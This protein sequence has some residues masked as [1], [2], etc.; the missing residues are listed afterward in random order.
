MC[1]IAGILSFTG[2]PTA[3]PGVDIPRL[4]QIAGNI[5]E[6][7]FEACRTK[8]GFDAASYMGGENT[9][10][11]FFQ[12]VRRLKNTALFT[13]I[14]QT[15]AILAELTALARRLSVIIDSEAGHFSDQVGF[16]PS[17]SVDA[18]SGRIECLKDI[19]WCI[20]N[21]IAE[22]IR[23]IQDLVS[24]QDVLPTPAVI[25]IFKDINAVL[26]SL[27]RLEVRG[28]DSAGISLMFYLKKND[29]DRFQKVLAHK[30]QSESSGLAA[31]FNERSARDILGN[32]DISL[33]ESGDDSGQPHVAVTFTYKVAAEIGRLGENILFIRSQ[34]KKDRILHELTRLPLIHHTISA[35]TRWASVGEIT[36]PNCHP[37]DSKT[38]PQDVSEKKPTIHVC[39]N[40]DIDNFHDLKDR[41]QQTGKQIPETIT[42]DTKIIPLQIEA[43]LNGGAGI[44][45]AFRRAVND[46]K[47]SHA[48]CMH[49]DLAP[50]KLFLAQR[51][52]GQAIFVG[53]ADDH[54]MPAS[55]V[56]GFVEE[57]PNYLKINGA[58]R[59][60]IFILSQPSNGGLDGIRAMY[61]DGTPITLS[62][63]DVKMTDITSRDIDRQAFAHYF[64]KEI[65][66][67][68]LSVQKTLQNRWKIIKNNPLQ[69]AV[70]LDETVIP[71]SLQT[72]LAQDRIRR[73]FF[74]GQGTA[75]I[76]AQVCSDILNYYLNYP[77]YQS[78]SLKA[79]ELSGF[80]LDAHDG[81]DSMADAL[82]IAISQSG[83]TTDT[84][85]TIDMVRERGAHTLAIVNRRDSD[86]T[87]KVDGVLY[88]SSGRDIEMSVA[89]TK[90]FYSQIVAGAILGLYIA[91]QKKSRTPEFIS[92]EIHEL[93]QLPAHMEKILSMRTEI[94]KSA[95]RLALGK[96]Y[97]AVVGS[98]PNKAS[99]DEIRIKLSELCYKTI[100]SDFIEDKKHIDLSSEPLIIVCA[101]GVKDTVIADIVKDT[102]IFNAHKATPVVIADEG[103]HRFDPFAADVFH[104]PRVSQHLA[105]IVNAL[106][107]HI[108]GYYAA[109]AINEESKFLFRFREEIQTTI[110][111]KTLQGLNI[112]EILLENSFKEK[113]AKFYGEFRKKKAQNRFPAAIAHET[114][115]DLTLLLKY[116]LGKLPVADFE[117]DFGLKST[118]LNL[119]N[120]F[121]KY[122]GD[123]INAMARPV[124][125][126][127]HQA[128]T[129]TVGTSR[130]SDKIE[131][132]VFEGLYRENIH[133]S[134]LTNNNI[135]VLK[136]LQQIISR[137]KGF[138]LYRIKG[139]N[140]LGELTDETTIEIVKKA[141]GLKD[142]PSRVEIDSQLKGTKRIIVREGNV[143]IGKGNRDDRSILIVP[144]I[145][146][147]ASTL[148]M[149]SHL[150]LFYVSF[151]KSIPLPVKIRALGGKYERIKNIV[152]ENSNQWDDHYLERI[153]TEELFGRSAEKIGD[154]IVAR[155]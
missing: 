24:F 104:V 91:G 151:K 41:Y 139:L 4:N 127:K 138:I 47:G 130:I 57:T 132:L 129:V 66:E 32:L 77:I 62:R 30:D 68:P 111:Q 23:K 122:L 152:Q 3:S 22:N 28:R 40:G 146:A 26:N 46:F 135:L 10:D 125:A 20:R 108:W 21:E 95:K 53:L 101:A 137:I 123:T 60:Q 153:E 45:E 134:Q 103:E 8:D 49:T 75:G 7:L 110:Q 61:Y 97:W 147:S 144:I 86:V 27:D 140:I 114:A 150:F 13:E 29:F 76:A 93:L 113:T 100:S 148:N 38:S 124:D 17:R 55:E 70:T 34:I 2:R 99:A 117:L 80:R 25:Q 33:H 96:P 105:P 16:L 48:I 81:P 5:E 58:T 84:N 72:A 35:H 115:S 98:G 88:T 126:I 154:V 15:P 94:E 74:M 89:S 131:G 59:G 141:G 63:E 69:L 107:G 133:I 64:L 12:A 19:H 51:G 149:I 42:T 79:S 71:E 102:A 67:S 73:I 145:S 50:G 116:L 109:L 54:Y 18:V 52:S 6:H 121:F 65:S 1:G 128:K 43:H 92:T 39:L 56:Y 9:V 142:L 85:R 11:A 87:F 120:T 112:Y 90:A 37:L 31:Q 78:S 82:V 44:Q 143:Y 119:L 118:P 14:M 36:E 155:L 136:N 106:V 83:T